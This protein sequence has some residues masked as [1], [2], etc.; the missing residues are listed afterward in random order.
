MV[1]CRALGA[2]STVLAACGVLCC[3]WLLGASGVSFVIRRV[4]GWCTR[5]VVLVAVR[6]QNID[7]AKSASILPPGT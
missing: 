3:V 7:L 5:G 6:V 1:V 2:F 4:C